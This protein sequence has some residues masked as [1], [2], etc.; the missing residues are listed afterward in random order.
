MSDEEKTHQIHKLQRDIADLTNQINQLRADLASTK[1][2]KNE[3]DALYKE[4]NSKS[5]ASDNS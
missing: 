3:L 1:K 2:A 4:A 5:S